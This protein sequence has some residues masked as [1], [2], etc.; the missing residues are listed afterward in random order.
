MTYE[1]LNP[2]FSEINR[3]VMGNDKVLMRCSTSSLKDYDFLETGIKYFPSKYGFSDVVLLDF[4]TGEDK[5]MIGT[6]LESIEK[7]LVTLFP[8][9]RPGDETIVGNYVEYF[10]TYQTQENELFCIIVPEGYKDVG[11]YEDETDKVIEVKFTEEESKEDRLLY[12]ITTYNNLER[13]VVNLSYTAYQVDKNPNRK[14]SD[15][16]LR[17]DSLVSRWKG[18]RESKVGLIFSEVSGSLVGTSEI[19]SRPIYELVKKNL[20]ERWNPR[21]I[22]S[23][24]DRVMIGENEYI[25][26]ESGNKGNHPFYTRY[27][28]VYD[29]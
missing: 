23:R 16:V 19:T 27:W 14:M 29:N 11:L 3:V 6:N 28:S 15:V 24:G 10:S 13:M 2:S 25:S 17:N 20:S 21:V 26:L 9:V 22:Y 12:I 5:S 7:Y 8:T 4:L 1:I 18:I